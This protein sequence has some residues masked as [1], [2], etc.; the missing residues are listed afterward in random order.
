MFPSL[1]ESLL[2]YTGASARC[3]WQQHFKGKQWPAPSHLQKSL[4]WSLLYLWPSVEVAPTTIHFRH[5]GLS[6][7]GSSSNWVYQVLSDWD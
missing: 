6:F 5:A 2:L 4:F 7:F 1:T 3:G